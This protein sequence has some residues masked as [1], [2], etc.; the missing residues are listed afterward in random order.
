MTDESAPSITLILAIAFSAVNIIRIALQAFYSCMAERDASVKQAN[1]A[2]HYTPSD[3]KNL[4]VH[5]VANAAE[6]V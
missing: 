4:S 1:S 6:Q 5:P 2:G 3:P